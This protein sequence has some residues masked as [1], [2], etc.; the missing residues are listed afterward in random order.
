MVRLGLDT[1]GSNGRS[2]IG[3]AR[4]VGGVWATAAMGSETVVAVPAFLAGGAAT[5]ALIR[6]HD[7]AAT[8]L[9]PPH[10]WPP[11][12]ATLVGVMFGANQP[13]FVAWGSEHTLLYNDAYADLLATKH[14]TAL[15]RPFFDVWSEVRDDL[16]PLVARVS[17]GEP[18]HM[19][20]IGLVVQRRGFP[21]EVHFSFS[22]SPVRDATGVVAGFFCPCT[23]TTQQVQA[24][25]RRAAETLRQLRMFEQAP[26]FICT[27]HG[28]EHVFGFVNNAHR[29]LF[30]ERG[31][32]GK[33]V[34]E[35]FP[36]LE[37]Q[38]FYELLDRVYVT[39]QRYVA[40]SHPARVRPLPEGPEED[41][42]LDFIYEPMRD[43][44]GLVV[45]IFCEGFD[46]TEGHRAQE[47]LRRSEEF[48]RRVLASSD[49]CIKVLDLD[50][51]L[52]TMSEG[53]LRALGIEDLTPFVGRCWADTF[54]PDAQADAHRAVA[55]ARAGR[56]A[57]FEGRLR[58]RRGDVHYWDSV[59][60]PVADA[61][62][63]PEK[64]LAMSRDVTAHRHTEE[65]MR[66]SEARFRNMAD[67]APVMMWVTDANGYCTYLNRRWYE[68]TGQTEAEALGIGWTGAT[69]P[70]DRKKAEDAFLSANDAQAPFRVEYRLK[71]SD[72]IYRWAI[73]AASP[74]YG[75]DGT[76]LG[77]VGSVIDIDERREA[78]ERLS[79]SEEVLRLATE[80]ADVGTWD[81]DLATGVLTWSDRTKAAFGISPGSPCTLDDFYAGLHPDERQATAEAFASALNPHQRSTYDAEYRTIG[82][83]DRLVRWVSA[84]GRGIFDEDGRCVRAI[85]TALDITS[86]KEVVRRLLTSE[87]ALRELNA[88]LEERVEERTRE[89]GVAEEA[90]RQSQKMDAVG[91]LTGGVAHD[92]NNL[93]TVIKSSTDLLKRPD[94]PE[95]RR[96]RYIGAISDTVARAAK[97]T[98]QL[99]AFAR[100]QALRPEVFDVGEAVKA[101]TDMVV[102]LTGSRIR[103]ETDI[104]DVPCSVNADPSQFDTALVNMAVNA[105]DA[106]DG[107]GQLTISVH[108]VSA[109]PAVQGHAPVAGDFVAVGITD[110][111]SGI[112][113]EDINRIFEPFFTTKGVGQG[114]G[115]G[116]SQV[117]GFAK[118]S[119]GEVRV[120]SEVSKGTTFVLYLP[121]VT[122]QVAAQ[123][124]EPEALIDGHGT[125]VLVVEDN[126]EVGTFATQTLAELGYV[127][128]WVTGADKALEELS[129][130]AA[131]YDV[132]FSD[133]VM[134]G[135]NGIDLA[136]EIRRLHHD[137]P[138]VLASGY[139]HVLAQNG[140]YG[141]ELLHKPYS[142]EELSRILR[143]VATWKRRR[144]IMEQ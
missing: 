33:T 92:F 115:L 13:M 73:D 118:Q 38:G 78:E 143:K 89:L 139:S 25:R 97:L 125:R 54:E 62:G 19:D 8:P 74:R 104:S 64:I 60:T 81:L 23:E 84:K 131:G 45:G 9:G 144:R 110:T 136:H 127:T 57:R 53:G 72:G 71:R 67:N 93:L 21:E 101:L 18:V 95:E 122:S 117:F 98:G 103:I 43:D 77:Y 102:T 6:A 32:V 76:F 128:T 50:G 31:L 52:E 2:W 75:E 44:A 30:G 42:L 137:L 4:R 141:F 130:D 35:G 83:E 29:R 123:T 113:P 135:M 138:V 39:G 126:I 69:H 16:V 47:A 14:P 48:S 120:Q 109:I 49:D 99:L 114:T 17:A 91:Q 121:R 7:W 105:R 132:V 5:G 1:Y 134:P 20:D 142:V 36:D 10:A 85:G 15:G 22:Y 65:A 55:R 41:R 66:E 133:V 79:L 70:N 111:G 119:C 26:G 24:E 61:D 56:T 51:S 37:G 108:R 88:T 34:R 40:R 94:L 100:R 27:M 58:T 82:K 28:P 59:L 68:F 96:Q 90:L 63:R 87:T 116:L 46:V 3:T 80:A 106:M 124:V 107:E 12:L 11:S 140:T 86:R 129:R 112:A